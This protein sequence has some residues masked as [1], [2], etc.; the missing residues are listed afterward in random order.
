MFEKQIV[1]ELNDVV[2]FFKGLIAEKDDSRFLKKITE[3]PNIKEDHLKPFWFAREFEALCKGYEVKK[4]MKKDKKELTRCF[5][6]VKER[7]TRLN[8][9]HLL[10]EAAPT[11]NFFVLK[12]ISDVHVQIIEVLKHKK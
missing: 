11:R 9:Q 8:L 7:L 4:L 12:K 2:T 5:K 1:D 6:E 3:N 10:A